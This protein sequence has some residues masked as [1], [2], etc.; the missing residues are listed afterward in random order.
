MVDRITLLG[1]IE[2]LRGFPVLEYQKDYDAWDA[3]E[4][5]SD[6]ECLCPNPLVSVWVATYNQQRYIRDCLNSIV[7]QKCSF[8]YEVIISEDNSSDATF[9]IC[10]EFQ[11]LY[12]KIIRVIHNKRNLY[13]TGVTGRRAISLA[14]GRYIAYC[15]GDDYWCNNRKLEKQVQCFLDDR[16]CSICYTD[17]YLLLPGSDKLIGPELANSGF[18]DEG[19][20]YSRDDYRCERHFL[21]T[22]V[23]F[24]TA[25]VMARKDCLERYYRNGL[26]HLRLKEGIQGVRTTLPLYGSVQCVRQAC[27]VY[28]GGVGVGAATA[29]DA[30]QLVLIDGLYSRVYATW[31]CMTQAEKLEFIRMNCVSRFLLCKNMNAALRR[32]GLLFSFRLIWH[33]GS[34]R[35]WCKFMLIWLLS[36]VGMQHW[37]IE[38]YRALRRMCKGK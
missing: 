34:L 10:K 28:R 7:A 4:E 32:R 31:D 36:V 27:A 1:W 12:P 16:D 9:E 6:R 14:R 21:K 33:V 30:T 13:G 17:S 35:H 24:K 37:T 18:F 38:S 22:G 3:Y 20:S 5:T 15:E 8:E 25:S 23:W 29:R 19:I 2:S 11:R 26:G